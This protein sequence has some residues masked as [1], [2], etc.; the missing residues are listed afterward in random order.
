MVSTT[1]ATL[2]NYGPSVCGQTWAGEVASA[3]NTEIDRLHRVTVVR[4]EDLKQVEPVVGH[5]DLERII[6]TLL[7]ESGIRRVRELTADLVNNHGAVG[8]LFT[9]L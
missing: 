3:G 5:H 8:G 2:G 4:L 7:G 6:A 1:A 9:T